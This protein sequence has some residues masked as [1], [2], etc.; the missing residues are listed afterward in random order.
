[1]KSKFLLFLAFALS[2][3]AADSAATRWWR[4]VRFL[5]GDSLQGRNTG[6]EGYRKAGFDV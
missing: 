4:D 5:A 6:S 3:V 1:M 2:L